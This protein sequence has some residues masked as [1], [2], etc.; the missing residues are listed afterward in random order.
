[1]QSLGLRRGD[2]EVISCPTCSRCSVDLIEL[3]DKFRNKTQARHSK[4]SNIKVA[5][6][7]CVVNGPGEASQA[8]IGVAFGGKKAALFRKGEIVTQ[9]NKEQALDSLLNLMEDFNECK[10]S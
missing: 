4:F 7:G 8:D 5:I 1:L 3:V 10:R 6:M 9:V 2:I